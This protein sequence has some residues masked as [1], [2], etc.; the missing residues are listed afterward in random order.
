MLRQSRGSSPHLDRPDRRRSAPPV[1]EPVPA[2]LPPVERRARIPAVS[3]PRASRRGSRPPAGPTSRWSSRPGAP[4][5]AAVFTPNAFAAAPVAVRR[6]PRGHGGGD[7]RG[8]WARRRRLDLGLRECRD[9]GPP[10][11]RTRRRSARRRRRAVDIPEDQVLH[12]STGIIGTRLPLDVVRAGDR[13]ARRRG[14]RRQDE[15]LAAAATALRTT[16][17]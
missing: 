10:A 17:P 5:A 16:D 6:E 11:T 9:R 12:L 2:D 1:T 15:A 8:G 7:P 13:L 3:G 4:S 14:A